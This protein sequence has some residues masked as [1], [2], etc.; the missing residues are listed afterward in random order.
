MKKN[1]AH[2]TGRRDA[3]HKPNV[4]GSRTDFREMYRAH[5]AFVWTNLLRLGVR[6]GAIDDAV[7]DVF[8]VVHRRLPTFEARAATRTWLFAIVRRVA[9]QHRRTHRRADRRLRAVAAQPVAPVEDPT[10]RRELA[11]LLIEALAELEEK[12]RAAIVLHALDGLPGPEVAAILGV[13][14]DTAYSR[15]KAGRRELRRALSRRGITASADLLQ[16]ARTMTSPRRVD[17][18]RVAVGLAVK[19]GAASSASV[20]GL[21][22]KAVAAAAVI[23]TG[24]T[25]AVSRPAAA[26][27][28]DHAP[29]RTR[30]E[31]RGSDAPTLH[32]N[33]AVSEGDGPPT[34]AAVRVERAAQASD[35]IPRHVRR[36]K[37]RK[38]PADPTP[39][40]PSIDPVLQEIQLVQEV[41]AAL[42]R[43][44][45]ARALELLDTLDAR[46][47]RELAPERMAYRAIALCRNGDR[48]AGIDTAARAE[49]MSAA[50]ADRVESSCRPDR[51]ETETRAAGHE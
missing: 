37:R 46:P 47:T 14:T 32:T 1:P 9:A 7:Q 21:L 20:G 31:A 26:V 36:P 45:P 10:H 30:V 13:K 15:I 44:K 41:R 49:R 8:V 38:P 39:A 5:F 40:A 48:Q 4:E 42:R 28:N 11:W 17:R 27:P 19:L 50:L 25:L 18:Q 16:D 33:V 23:A 2:V 29:A 3:G 24:G 43:G 12:Q 22:G 35:P 34:N 6:R 51:D